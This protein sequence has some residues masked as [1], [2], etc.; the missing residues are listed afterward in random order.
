MKNCTGGSLG[1]RLEPQPLSVFLSSLLLLPPPRV[2]LESVEFSHHLK[3]FLHE[4]S[5]HFMHEFISF[6]KSPFD[7]IAY[8]SRVRYQWPGSARPPDNWD[9]EATQQQLTESPG[10]GSL[11]SSLL[12]MEN[13]AV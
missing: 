7:M 5:A 11:D 2:D 10:G 4:K 8:D 12:D 13:A 9:P 3:P 1:T 6:A